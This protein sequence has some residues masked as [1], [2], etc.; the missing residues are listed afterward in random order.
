M[1]VILFRW[2]IIMASLFV[3][4]WLVPGIYVSG[5]NAWVAFAVMAA[6]L[7]FVDA[8]VKPILKLVSCGCIA[9]TMGLFL[10]FINAF[11]LWFSSWIAINWF[12]IN[13]HVDGFWAALMGSIIVSIVSFLLG[14]FVPDN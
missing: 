5:T 13:F 9:I 14:M 1:I 10:L 12:N 3:A 11:T 8:L 7:A 2:L 6:I 4:V